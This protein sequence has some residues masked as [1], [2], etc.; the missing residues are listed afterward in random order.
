MAANPKRYKVGRGGAYERYLMDTLR[1][2]YE[3]Q[4]EYFTV[5]E[6]CSWAG[7]PRSV[8][9]TEILDALV[10]RGWLS[11]EAQELRTGRKGKV[12]SLKSA[13]WFGAAQPV[14]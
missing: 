1:V 7:L 12:Y 5:R 10:K 3:A 13:V 11:V 2:M 6:F 14:Q 9:M 8:T 4:I